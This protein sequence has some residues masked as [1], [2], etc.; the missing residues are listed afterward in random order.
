MM[1]VVVLADDNIEA[2]SA[3]V[4][5]MLEVTSDASMVTETVH[6]CRNHHYRYPHYK[7]Q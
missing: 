6:L 1:S 5:A 4:A 3:C 7:Q 2:V